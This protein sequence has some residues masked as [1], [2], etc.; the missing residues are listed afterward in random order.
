[1]TEQT[2]IDIG[3]EAIMVA[4]KI[5][6]PALLGIMISGLIISILQAAT[7]INEQTLSFI[8]KIIVM[9]GA[10][11][12]SSSWIIQTITFFTTTLFKRIATITQ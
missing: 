5:A 7:Q 2:I 1:M 12:F 9:T 4:M 8:P 6:S 11:I 10:L 3:A